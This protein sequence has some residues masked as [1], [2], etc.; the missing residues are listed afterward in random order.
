MWDDQRADKKKTPRCRVSQQTSAGS[1]MDPMLPVSSS[2]WVTSH[3]DACVRQAVVDH[4]VA[5]RDYLGQYLEEV[6]K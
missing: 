6:R 2:I 1:S 3:H 4:V 5:M